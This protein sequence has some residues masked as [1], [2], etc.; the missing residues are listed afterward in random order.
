ML[1]YPE[2]KKV[3]KATRMPMNLARAKASD[4]VPHE[5][6]RSLLMGVIE[7]LM[8]SRLLTQC[9]VREPRRGRVPG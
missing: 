2:P 4:P 8:N 5:T 3:R 6:R 7:T 9:S 1:R